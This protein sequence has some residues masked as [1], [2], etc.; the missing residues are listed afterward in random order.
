MILAAGN[1][2]VS[3]YVQ[4]DWFGKG[5]FWA[6]FLLSILSW[7]VIA[8]KGWLLFHVRRLSLDFASLF[9]EK[10]P[11][12]LQYNRHLKGRLLE[13]PHPF[14]EVY[15]ALKQNALQII[16]RNHLFS[17]G[18]ETTFSEA[19]FG[20]IE[21]HVRTATASQLKRLEKNLFILST[22]VTLGPFLGLLGTVWGIL[23]TFS[24][25]QEKGSVASNANML[26]GLSLALA[27]T[28][29][30]LVVAIPALVGYNYLKNGLREYRREAE[31]FSHLLVSAIELHY[32]K[33]EDAK[34]SD[35]VI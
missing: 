29:V 34:I 14:F 4:S 22:V 30:G 3:A 13:I 23:L 8:H 16:S 25:L 18:N 1:P 9:C 12:A 11:L 21:S 17:P 24:Q 10:D 20:L 26:T 5:I 32:R 31:D 2:F 7:S 19:D 33:P 15:K 28:V 27:T 6:L 35:S